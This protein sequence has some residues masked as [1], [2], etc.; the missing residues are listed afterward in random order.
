[1]FIGTYGCAINYCSFYLRKK[2][3]NKIWID[4]RDDLYEW[5]K[6]FYLTEKI[7]IDVSYAT[8]I[9]SHEFETFLPKHNYFYMH[10][11]DS[12]YKWMIENF[13]HTEDN[14]GKIR[15]SF[16]GNVRYYEQNKRLLTLLGNDNRFKLQYYGNGSKTLEDYCKKNN[17][18]NVEFYGA[19]QQKDTIKFYEKTDIINNM[20][21]NE[22]LNLRVALSN[23]LYYG[24]FLELPIL[25]SHDT[26]MEKL[27]NEYNIGYTFHED[28]TFADNL[29]NWYCEMKN[30]TNS[31]RFHDLW[32]RFLNEDSDSIEK[33]KHFLGIIK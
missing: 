12:N 28:E 25:V 1:M 29:Y 27:V 31:P 13:N 5:F 19:F 8:T 22:T 16:I 6:P 20:Y 23:K 24:L 3:K 26:Y 30:S 17:I 4:V 32:K 14:D 10:N 11:I 7:G 15:I 18:L 33:L 2:Y 9:S 21:G